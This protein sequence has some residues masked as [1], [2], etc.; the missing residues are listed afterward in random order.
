MKHKSFFTLITTILLSIAVALPAFANLN[1]TEKIDYIFNSE[2]NENLKSLQ[3]A[4]FS[5]YLSGKTEPEDI[6]VIDDENNLFV[7]GPTDDVVIEKV[8]GKPHVFIGKN[9]YKQKHKATSSNALVED[10]DIQT[11]IDSL[12]FYVDAVKERTFPMDEEEAY[13]YLRN[14][15]KNVFYRED[16][17]ANT[18]AEAVVNRTGTLKEQAVMFHIL[19]TNS[20]IDD[21][22][23]I[24]EGCCTNISK[25]GKKYIVASF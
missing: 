16:N 20:G 17:G 11:I 25:I 18:I 7:I 13:Q 9:R 3:K 24:S 19:A 22:I 21:N 12:V 14:F 4:A 5:Y 10:A 1:Y 15:T 8:D 2:P 6:G 23:S